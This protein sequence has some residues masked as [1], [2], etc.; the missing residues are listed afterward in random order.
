MRERQGP[1][2]QVRCGMRNAPEAKLDRVDNLMY[3]YLAEVVL[4]LNVRNEA[5]CMKTGIG[6]GGMHIKESLISQFSGA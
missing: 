1:E 3:H 2:S 6:S 4:L 5:T